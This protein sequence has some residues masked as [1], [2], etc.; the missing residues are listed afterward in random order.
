M[1]SRVICGGL[2]GNK[3]NNAKNFSLIYDLGKW[4]LAPAYDKTYC[5]DGYHGEHATSINNQGIPSLED[6]FIVAE[7]NRIPRVKAQKIV[8]DMSLICREMISSKYL[9]STFFQ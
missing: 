3:V 5:K 2:V 1:C 7:G 4:S 6:M 9:H 8:T